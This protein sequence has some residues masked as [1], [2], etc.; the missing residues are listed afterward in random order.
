MTFFDSMCAIDWAIV[1]DITVALAAIFSASV[2]WLGI[3]AWKRQLTGKAA[4]DAAYELMKE[5]YKWKNLLMLARHPLV[6]PQEQPK[7]Y[8]PLSKDPS[9]VN[10]AEMYN[11][12]LSERWSRVSECLGNIESFSYSAKPLVGAEKIETAIKELG[13]CSGEWFAAADAYVH[14]L[15]SGGLTFRDDP[16]FGKDMRATLWAKQDGSDKLS[17][18][19]KNALISLEEATKP[20]LK[21]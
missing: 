10:T 7:G 14:N 15:A 17:Q 1:K 20:Y 11:H 13:S 9:K 5:A 21:H 12:V 8:D 16:E 3:N 6:T 2:A 19:I 4:F 18:K